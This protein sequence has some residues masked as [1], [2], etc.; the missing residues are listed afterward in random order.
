M[1]LSNHMSFA[2]FC[3]PFCCQGAD[4]MEANGGAHPRVQAVVS[5]GAAQQKSTADPARSR[6][7]RCRATHCDPENT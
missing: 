6:R 3:A 1:I 7:S 5:P 4:T 2:S